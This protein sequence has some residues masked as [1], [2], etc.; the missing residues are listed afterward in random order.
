MQAERP[1]DTGTG[2]T[3]WQRFDALARKVTQTPKAQVDKREKEWREERAKR[4]KEE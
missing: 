2:A 1:P 3:P 4:R